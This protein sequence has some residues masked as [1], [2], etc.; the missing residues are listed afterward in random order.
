MFAKDPIR[1]RARA[2]VAL[3]IAAGLLVVTGCSG[4]ADAPSPGAAGEEASGKT[5]EQF[6]IVTPEKESDHGWNQQGIWAAQAAADELGIKLDDNS[7]V[8]YDNTETILNQVAESGN[9]FIIA[10]ASGFNTPGHRVG[11]QT[12]VPVL[13]TDIEQNVPGKVGT[14]K[15]QAQEGGYLAGVAAAMKTSTGTVGIVAS[16][17]DAN[18]FTMSGGFAEGV[19]SIDPSVEIVIAYVGPAS[20]GDSAGGATVAN[21]VIATGADVIFGMGDG[22][23]MGYLQAIET[24]KKDYPLFYIAS[25]GDVSSIV[26]DTSLILTSVL[27]DYTPTYVQAIKDIESGK[28]GTTTYQLTVE[29]GG[30]YLQ[31]NDNLS[32]EILAAVEKAKSGIIDGSISVSIAKSAAEVQSK[33]DG[34]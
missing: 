9:D 6:A 29:N 28:F 7:N 34:A 24:A 19:H 27:W 20:Y 22:A 23:T 31:D 33:I 2:G 30:L 8:G 18:W 32:P 17:E 26:D 16:A 11:M 12:G 13:V 15:T 3:V 4:R 1:T 14:V 21:Q 25:I 10:H 5:V